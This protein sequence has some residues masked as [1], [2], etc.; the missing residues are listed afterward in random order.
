[1]DKDNIN[2]IVTNFEL[3]DTRM[4]RITNT[5]KMG[6]YVYRSLIMAELN[7]IVKVYQPCKNR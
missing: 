3:F 5:T 7:D 2:F 6:L 4:Q 1:M